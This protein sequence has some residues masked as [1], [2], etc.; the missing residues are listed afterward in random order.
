MQRY[1]QDQL[2]NHGLAP[3]ATVELNSLDAFRGLVRQGDMIALLP[4]SALVEARTDSALVVK[5]L[6][7]AMD[8]REVVLVTTSDRLEI[9]P[10]QYFCSLITQLLSQPRLDT[11]SA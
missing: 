10:I 1:V 3:T 8:M 5:P 2:A 6:P 4:Q 11:L 9:P 7:D